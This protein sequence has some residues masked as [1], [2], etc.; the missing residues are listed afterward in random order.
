MAHGSD[1][2]KEIILGD[3]FGEVIVRAN[4][5]TVQIHADSSVETYPNDTAANVAR[6]IGD[7][8]CDGDHKGEIYGGILPSDNKPIWFSQPAPRLMNHY[9]AAA[10]AEK[11]GGSLPTRKQGDYLDTIKVQGAFKQFFNRSGSFPAGYVWLAEPAVSCV[12]SWNWHA[13]SSSCRRGNPRAWWQ[14]LSDGAQGN[15][16]QNVKLPVLRVR[17]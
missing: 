13:R 9:N 4:G 2:A 8:E 16:S 14:R 12:A 6:E 1:K 15:G 10:W 5:A 3:D 7:I 17:R 11:Q